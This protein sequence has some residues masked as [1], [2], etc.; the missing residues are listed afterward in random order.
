MFNT[1][2]AFKDLVMSPVAAI[3]T[4]YRALSY[5][6]HTLAWPYLQ[7]H[8]LS[9]RCDFRGKICFCNAHQTKA[10]SESVTENTT[11][12]KS[13][14]SPW[15]PSRAV[16]VSSDSLDVQSLAQ[17]L[18]HLPAIFRIIVAPSPPCKK[19]ATNRN[20]AGRSTVPEVT[21]CFAWAEGGNFRLEI[22]SSVTTL[23]SR[24]LLRLL[25][26]IMPNHR[27]P[28]VHSMER[29]L[30]VLERIYYLAGND[31]SC[32][33]LDECCFLDDAPNGN[34]RGRNRVLCVKTDSIN[35]TIF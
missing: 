4:H 22:M 17:A 30:C 15:P 29:L 28:M 1:P 14:Q 26:S 12:P 2:A 33:M 3:P 8:M 18:L 20:Y 19:I 7:Q 13:G 24:F 6:Q 35:Q 21:S 25:I 5:K 27:S 32:R 9:H 11:E 10:K 34:S 31:F 23:A 16:I